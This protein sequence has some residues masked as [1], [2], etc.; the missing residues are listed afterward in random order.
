[1]INSIEN[2]K[3]G[4]HRKIYNQFYIVTSKL[5]SGFCF[6]TSYKGFTIKWTIYLN[7]FGSI[8]I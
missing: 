8:R 3:K 5:Q 2:N 4:G 1:M 7:H 6:L